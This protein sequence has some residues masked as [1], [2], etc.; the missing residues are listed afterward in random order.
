MGV[1][2]FLFPSPRQ[3]ERQFFFLNLSHTPVPPHSSPTGCAAYTAVTGLAAYH[4]AAGRSNAQQPSTSTASAH[5]TAAA[6][7]AAGT[8]AL[9]ATSASLVSLLATRFS[10]TPC[11]WCIG[12]AALSA[13][14]AAALFGSLS[15]PDLKAALAPGG[16]AA[17]ATA[18]ALQ[19]AWA[20]IDASAAAAADSLPYA[21]PEISRPSPP[22]A[23]DLARRLRA[24]GARMYGAF[25]CGHCFDQR[26]AFGAA[27]AT[28]L[29]YVE[30]YPDGVTRG[31]PGP[32]PVCVAAGI[33]GFPSWVMPGGETLEGEQTFAQLEDALKRGQ[34]RVALEGLLPR[35]APE[36]VGR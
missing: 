6:A 11:A 35:T 20:G 18:L 13:S 19:L 23:V 2:F 34:A 14:I 21:E 7:L 24:A 22:G 32:A 1:S 33:E 26:Q 15:R 36:L 8:A 29:P 30:C 9:A 25:W 31:G 3:V 4:W 16:C 12:S 17:L 5:P 28:E 10:D 27:A